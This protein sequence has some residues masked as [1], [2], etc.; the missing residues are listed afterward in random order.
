MSGQ[1]GSPK[2]KPVN[3]TNLTIDSPIALLLS[4]LQRHEHAICGPGEG[5]A[6]KLYGDLS[7]GF[8][9]ESSDLDKPVEFDDFDTLAELNRRLS[10]TK[11]LRKRA[12]RRK[13]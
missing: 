4:Y 13:K 11:P 8:I 10:N 6:L 3:P 2:P 1:T 9:D 12:H 7:G 5:T